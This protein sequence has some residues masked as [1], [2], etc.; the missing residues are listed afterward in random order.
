MLILIN[1]LA[2]DDLSSSLVCIKIVGL[3][4]LLDETPP[5]IINNKIK[6]KKTFK[7]FSIV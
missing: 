6:D 5:L 2:L 3:S 1:K 4:Y 7:C